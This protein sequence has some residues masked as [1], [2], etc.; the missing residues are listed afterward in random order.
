M[1]K[2]RKQKAS[3]TEWK[4]MEDPMLLDD[5]GGSPLEWLE[6][7]PPTRHEAVRKS[8]SSD[9]WSRPS[10]ASEN[11]CLTERRRRKLQDLSLNV[12]D[13]SSDDRGQSVA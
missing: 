5:P 7:D 1:A 6:F 10:F 12:E 8:E 3:G 4:L 13:E 11:D 2:R 9:P